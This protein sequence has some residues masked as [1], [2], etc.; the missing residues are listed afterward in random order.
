MLNMTQFTTV[1]TIRQETIGPSAETQI[2][3]FLYMWEIETRESNT[4]KENFLF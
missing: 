3:A 2:K 1:K 4:F